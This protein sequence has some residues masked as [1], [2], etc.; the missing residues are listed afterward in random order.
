MVETGE[1]TE[2][3]WECLGGSITLDGLFNGCRLQVFNT[4][5]ATLFP[6]TNINLGLFKTEWLTVI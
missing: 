6:N 5:Y 2:G 3:A 4:A 1:E